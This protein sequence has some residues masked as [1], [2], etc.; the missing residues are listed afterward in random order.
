M[1]L[2]IPKEAMYGLMLIFAILT[3]KFKKDKKEKEEKEIPDIFADMIGGV[4]EAVLFILIA[5]G[6]SYL[7]HAINF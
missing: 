4:I 1:I 2:A 7:I 5:W 6:I 3:V